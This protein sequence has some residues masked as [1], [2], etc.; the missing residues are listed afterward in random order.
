M[1]E[2]LVLALALVLVAIGIAGLAPSAA[3]ALAARLP[4]RPSRRPVGDEAD[5]LDGGGEPEDHVDAPA[6]ASPQVHPALVPP[7]AGA[8]QS[9]PL[10]ALRAVPASVPETLGAEEP[11]EDTAAAALAA[12]LTAEEEV[13]ADATMDLDAAEDDLDAGGQGDGDDEDDLMAL[14]RETKV[15]NST[16]TALKDA[17]QDV[18]AVDLLA[19]ARELRDLLRRAA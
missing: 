9:A 19:E 2:T 13:E 8:W 1:A 17:Y 6:G 4:S 3:N 14:F 10:P 16:P 7:L 5:L 12:E 18:S 15:T 11:G